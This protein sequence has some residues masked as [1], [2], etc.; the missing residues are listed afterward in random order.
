MRRNVLCSIVVLA[1]YGVASAQAKKPDK[2]PG[3]ATD[4]R[5][6]QLLADLADET[7]HQR[8]Y[9]AYLVLQRE[10]SVAALPAIV[11]TLPR[12]G[13][14]GQSLG[15]SLL[16]SYPADVGHPALRKLLDRKSPLLE[17]GAAAV[18][19]RSGDQ[20]SV[21]HIVQ[22][23]AR[24]DIAPAL[25][26]AMLN[27][28]YGIREPKISA[29][30]RS[31]IVPES[32]SSVLDAALNH[33]L[34][35]EDRESQGKIAALLAAPSVRDDTKALASAFAFALGDTN[36][37]DAVASAVRS[38]GG[39][40]LVRIQQY[41]QKT[42]RLPEPILQAITEI[43]EKSEV[44]YHVQTAIGLL[45]QHGSGK[46]IALFKKL[47]DH[48]NAQVAKAALEAIQKSGAGLPVDAL[49]R[50]LASEQV[51]LALAAADGLRKA[52]DPSGLPRVLEL[53]KSGATERAEAA[54]VLGNFRHPSVIPVL[55]EALLD[56]EPGVRSAAEQGLTRL[57][58]NLF[59]YRR[60]DMA[61]TGYAANGTP[62]ARAEAVQRIRA[63][64]DA[65]RA[66]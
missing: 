43:A 8:R 42:V 16:M 39:N 58:P 31:L 50:L 17:V 28:I 9:D 40:L 1:A 29:A 46:E 56:A 10:R 33:L 45:A 30:V 44:G 38:G 14:Q 61:S 60:F 32:D 18:L 65:H 11:E 12:C 22:P 55:I 20:S 51:S 4:K 53:L 2:S 5:L 41:L 54:R 6:E 35:V 63:W 64:W 24:G 15:L 52:D 34:Q 49:R 36:Q 21:E 7:N 26:S 3:G 19:F 66:K 27:R 59:P 57:L 23:L 47:L 48:K 37:A 25:K 62:S 13:P